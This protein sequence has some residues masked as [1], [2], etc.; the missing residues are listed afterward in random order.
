MESFLNRYRN[1]TVLLLVIFAQL[2]LLAV[3]VKNDQDVRMIR[4][5][6]VT[7]V[8]PVARVMEAF[9]G[10][11][12]GFVRNYILLH[13]VNAE[14]RRLQAEL[15][16]YKMENIALRNELHT[17]DRA[18][19][20]EVFQQQ[21]PSKTLAASVILASAGSNA[22]VRFLDRGSFSGVER[23]MAVV[24]PDGI[25]G[26]IIAAYP[27]ASEMLMV[28]DA[29]FAAGVMTQSG[30]RGILK[31]QGNPTLCKIDYIPVQENITVGEMLWTS[32]DD[33]VFP[34][35]FPV[36]TVKSV[37]NA[38]PFKEVYVEPSGIR[39]GV[40]DVL[41]LLE[42]VH[43]DIPK[44][45]PA[46]QPV[47][48]A[49]P[50]PAPGQN[51]GD[52]QAGPP[53]PGTEADKLRHEY[54][55][56]GDAQNHN[57]GE[58][59]PG[60]KPPDFTKLPPESGARVAT[61]PAGQAAKPPVQPPAGGAGTGVAPQAGQPAKPPPADP[62]GRAPA[63]PNAAGGAGSRGAAAGAQ[64]RPAAASPAGRGPATTNPEAAPNAPARRANQANGPGGQLPE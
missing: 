40:E 47:Y 1:I 23:G 25:V 43:E 21:T 30:V 18:K 64:P 55:A 9:R 32:G 31:G 12:I 38:Q 48:I 52:A 49:P 8:T 5:W 7:A 35:G 4:I 44:T 17:A 51:A 62:A 13:D 56:V 33:R 24:T 53:A 16:R 15:D 46:N 14:N 26:K 39:R 50:P 37:R 34:R 41:I 20:L 19:A 29:D 57:F 60:T 45:P 42:S 2:T 22:N 63:T 3:Q 59:G 27:S 28:T 11:G 10:G 6:T 36:G 58:G 61:P 54:K